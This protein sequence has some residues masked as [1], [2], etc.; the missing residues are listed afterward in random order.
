MKTYVD[1]RRKNYNFI[2]QTSYQAGNWIR[3]GIMASAWVG[4]NMLG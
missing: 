4:Y 3:L 2:R 1:N